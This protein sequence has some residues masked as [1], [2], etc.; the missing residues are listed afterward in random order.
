M[1]LRCSP[2]NRIF[3][4]GGPAKYKTMGEQGITEAEFDLS[5]WDS[6]YARVLVRDDAGRKAWTNPIWFEAAP[7]S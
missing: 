3:F 5:D 2:A 6:P 1:R 4:I 7:S